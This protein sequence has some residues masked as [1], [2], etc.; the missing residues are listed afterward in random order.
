MALSPFRGYGT[1]M[2]S[3]IFM[4]INQGEVNSPLR[5]YG[6][7][8]VSSTFMGTFWLKSFPFIMFL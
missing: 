7:I 5:G 2:V 4:A 1:I 8:M 6:T 3:S